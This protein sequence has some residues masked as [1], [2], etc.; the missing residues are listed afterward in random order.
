MLAALGVRGHQAQG[1]RGTTVPGAGPPP[2]TTIRP[3]GEWGLSSPW[4]PKPLPLLIRGTIPVRG[5]TGRSR[6]EEGIIPKVG[7]GQEASRAALT[8]QGWPSLALTA[9]PA[10][11]PP[12]TRDPPKMHISP[13]V[14]RAMP[15][16]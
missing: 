1:H 7:T 2:F 6:S 10:L 15:S 12:S 5:Y 14:T 3:R 9:R 8:V 16:R 11:L 13:E 4:P